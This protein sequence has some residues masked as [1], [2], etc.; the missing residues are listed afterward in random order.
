[1]LNRKKDSYLM[2]LM[3]KQERGDQGKGTNGTHSTQDDL[4]KKMF[5][6]DI[7]D[8]LLKQSRVLPTR[9]ES[10][11]SPLMILALLAQIVEQTEC[12]SMALIKIVQISS[13]LWQQCIT[14]FGTEY[15]KDQ[16]R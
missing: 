15:N 16:S 11:Q 6:S 12:I 4:G 3:L 2:K 8:H 13:I 7:F 14:T 5:R 1:M 10:I 9:Q